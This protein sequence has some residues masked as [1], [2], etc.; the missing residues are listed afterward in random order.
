MVRNG[1]LNATIASLV[2]AL[3]PIFAFYLMINGMNVISVLFFRYTLAL[4]LL[5]LHLT[6]HGRHIDIGTSRILPCCGVGV[7]IGMSSFALFQSFKVMD[8]G[9]SASIYYIYPL[10]IAMIY[11][12]FFHGKFTTPAFISLSSTLVGLWLMCGI[13]DEVLVSLRGM[14][15]ALISAL[16]YALSI[17]AVNRGRFRAISALCLT[18]WTTLS[19]AFIFGLMIVIRGDVILPD[20]LG[21]WGAILGMAICASIG[22]IYFTERAV[23]KIGRTASGMVDCSEPLFVL[24]F[25]MLFFGQTP[26]ITELVG[27]ILI[28]ASVAWVVGTRNISRDIVKLRHSHTSVS[29]RQ[30]LR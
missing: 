16:L 3:I 29:K 4:P 25:A 27:M 6:R 8:L 19:A 13:T 23:D 22:Q 10:I 28:V 5:W 18:F 7:L 21:S 30:R 15:M 14:G 9:I 12:A 2:S 17:I 20:S 26:T 24:I 1:Y 11:A